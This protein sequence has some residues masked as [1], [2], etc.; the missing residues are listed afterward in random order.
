MGKIRDALQ[1]PEKGQKRSK[2]NSKKKRKKSLRDIKKGEKI[3]RLITGKGCRAGKS[4]GERRGGSLKEERASLNTKGATNM[5]NF[6]YGPKERR[7]WVPELSS[8]NVGEM[9]K[10]P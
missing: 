1:R 5:S 10:K 8:I 4:V 6:L 7:K 2:E 3:G 9:L